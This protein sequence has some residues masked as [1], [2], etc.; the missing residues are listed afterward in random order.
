MRTRGSRTPY[1]TS[2][3]MFPKMTRTAMIQSN[4]PARNWSWFTIC[5][6]RV[7][8]SAGDRSIDAAAE[9]VEALGRPLRVD[10]EGLVA[11]VDIGRD[12][13][14]GIRIRAGDQDGRDITQVRGDTGRDEFLKEDPGRDEHLAAEVA[15]LLGTRELVFE[16]HGARAGFDQ[17]LRQL[18]GV[19]RAAESRFPVGHDRCEPVHV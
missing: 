18:E 6:R 19:Q 2:A 10:D 3:T 8:E 12:E 7:R 14:R 5:I 17:R 13:L 15:A 9:P 11:R 16:V 1:R 4:A